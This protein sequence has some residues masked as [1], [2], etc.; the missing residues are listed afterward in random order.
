MVATKLLL[1]PKKDTALIYCV[2]M[3]SNSYNLYNTH[4]MN[5]KNTIN[6]GI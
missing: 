6:V 4:T 2:R 5:E 1:L 3:L